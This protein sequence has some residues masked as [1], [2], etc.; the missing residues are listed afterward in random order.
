MQHIHL[1][2]EKD[3]EYQLVR[4]VLSVYAPGSEWEAIRGSGGMNNSTY[5]LRIDGKRFVLRQYE[6]HNDVA[7]IAFEH[8]ILNALARSG[9]SLRLPSPVKAPGSGQTF[10]TLVNEGTGQK[11][12]VALFRYLEGHNPVWGQPEQLRELGMAAGKLSQALAG[13]KVSLDPVYPPYYQIQDAYPLCTPDKLL[14]MCISPPVRLHAVRNDMNELAHTLPALF[15]ALAGM[16][17]LPH[18]LVHGDVNASNVL[19]DEEGR[20][21]AVLDFEFATW[22]LRVMELAVPLSDLL[23]ID[24]SEAW[25]WGA[26]ESL[27]CGYRAHAVLEPA[28]LAALPQLV[29]LRSLD[30]VMHF[31]S[32]MF[33]ETD[34]PEVAAVQIRKLRERMDWMKNNEARLRTLLS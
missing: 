4:Q 7:K 13:L 33:E 12:V 2:S 23:T 11:K 9:F 10:Y 21:C 28:E 8:E 17:H 15:E 34:P 3:L 5:L 29:L 22:D 1:R 31:I 27:I 16:E 32:R 18:Q 30:V 25:L 26:L 14:Q 19:A 24:H 6:T 20:V